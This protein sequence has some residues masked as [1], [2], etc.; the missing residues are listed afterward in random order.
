LGQGGQIPCEW[1]QAIPGFDNSGR[2]A[3]LKGFLRTIYSRFQGG[4]FIETEGIRDR[5]A[6][7]LWLAVNESL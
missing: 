7:I 2:G 4:R 3:A 6:T 5:V 1:A